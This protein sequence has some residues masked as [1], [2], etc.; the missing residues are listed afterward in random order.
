MQRHRGGMPVAVEPLE[1]RTLLSSV[2]G[3]IP[4]LS[5]I[6]NSLGGIK[7]PSFTNGL[8]GAVNAVATPDTN[9]YWWL[10]NTG[11]T[12]S[13]HPSGPAT[14]TSGADIN[15]LN[16][17]D[18]STGSSNVV[19]AVLDTGIDLNNS[20]LTSALWTNSKEIAGDGIDNDGNGKID[21][22]HGWNFLGNNNNLQDN[23]VHGTAVASAILSV[24]PGVKILPVEIGTATG[25][26]AQAVINAINYLIKLKK[27]G[28]NIVA[29]NAS[30][31]SFSAP[32]D[33]EIS[34]IKSAGDAG[35]LYVAAAGNAGMSLDPSLPDWAM[36]YVS[37]YLPS[38]LVF[39]AA[40][41]NQDH[42]ASFSDYG[43]YTVAVGAPGVDITL[44]IPGGLYASLSGTSFAAP[45]VSGIAALLK[46]AKPTATMGQIKS[47]ILNSGDL[48]PALTNKTITGR[49][50]DAYRALTYLLG[51]KTI[52][53][54]VT[55]LDNTTLSGWAF[56]GNLGSNPAT[57][58]ITMDGQTVATLSANEPRT[59]LPTQISSPNHGFTFDTSATPY[60]KHAIK[61]Y[62]VDDAGK[63]TLIGQGTLTVNTAPTGAVETA[64]TKTLTGWTFD[65][66]TPGKYTQVKVFLDGKAWITTNANLAR[67]DLADECPTDP[68]VSTGTVKHGFK[69]NLGAM[70]PGI[71]R[72][73]VYAV[74]T[75]TKELTLIG[76]QTLSSN[77]QATGNVEVLNNTTLSGWAFDPD[78]KAG[79]IQI[80]YQIDDFAPV[81]VTANQPRP[82][83]LATLGS[84]SHGFNVAL[85]QL[86]A[87]DHTIK[88]W[89]VDKNNKSL[90]ELTSQTLT[91]TNPDGNALPTG[92]VTLSPTQVT[93]TLTDGTS[94][95]PITV[96][97]E[98]D[99]GRAVPTRYTTTAT[100][101]SGTGDLQFTY[102]LPKITGARRVD[103]YALDDQTGAA[104]LLTRRLLNYTAPTATVESFTSTGTN[105]GAVGTAIAPA[106]SR[107]LA[108]VRLD[109]DGLTG[110]LI[111]ANVTRRDQL[112]ILG[113]TNVGYSIPLPQLTPGA[114]TATLY[115]V[116][117]TT[118]LTTE[119]QELTFTV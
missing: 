8:L 119:L 97:I 24:A 19:V 116:D 69:I 85:P 13:Q 32:S 1:S 47:A 52:Q 58:R 62:V 112:T 100:L 56:D 115:L 72:I 66:N 86:T 98:V 29:I 111:T 10:N 118:L 25:D 107:G 78:A 110:A 68:A 14:G 39:V 4:G 33:T 106:A 15:A 46:S 17:W 108:F 113:R 35:M 82:D 114:H 96:R 99:M 76:T 81:F 48:D 27:A 30:Y 20:T 91:V 87:G 40:T 103:V 104:V 67:T 117:P 12:L 61:V 73:D 41:D 16:A 3:G 6:L 43:K 105:P 42:L 31:I 45:M 23:F 70:R 80:E 101:D 55:Q 2:L 57:V 54:A 71:H 95:G 49:R 22:I 59:D 11:Q 50:V 64:T 92:T 75:L 26:N 21:D 36:K 90:T 18:I 60:G 44:Q 102:I 53:G 5:D 109:I 77:Q 89:A 34:A 51:I 84:K 7:L 88:V 94:T 38:N 79:A 93:G 65:S 28:V 83:L 37:S 9:D 63:L 74:D